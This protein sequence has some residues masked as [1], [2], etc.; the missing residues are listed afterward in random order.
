M[1]WACVLGPNRLGK[2]GVMYTEYHVPKLKSEMH[3]VQQKRRGRR[4][5]GGGRRGRSNTTTNQKGPG[6]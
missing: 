4:R 5:K 2:K 6:L 3:W 1:D